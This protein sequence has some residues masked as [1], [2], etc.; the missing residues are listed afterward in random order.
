MQGR[1][2]SLRVIKG[3]AERKRLITDE[4]KR[5]RTE[6]AKPRPNWRKVAE[7]RQWLLV[8]KSIDGEYFA[9]ISRIANESFRRLQRLMLEGNPT[10]SAIRREIDQLIDTLTRGMTATL[11]KVSS[12]RHRASKQDLKRQLS[13]AQL[14]AQ[15]GLPVSLGR[16][17]PQ[18]G[19][20]GRIV[21][22]GMSLAEIMAWASPLLMI[23]GERIAEDQ[24][25]IEDEL[26]RVDPAEVVEREEKEVSRQYRKK[27]NGIVKNLNIANKISN[28]LKADGERAAIAEAKRLVLGND[29]KAG[30]LGQLR[31]E[32]KHEALRIAGEHAE[33]RRKQLDDDILVG[34]ILYSRFLASSAPDHTARDGWRF[35]RDNRRSDNL[36]KISKIRPWAQRRIP[37]YRKNCV[38]FTQ[39]IFEDA[40]GDEFYAEFSVANP[41]L[42]GARRIRQSDVGAQIFDIL[43]GR[44]R[45]VT[46]DDVGTVIAGRA[47]SGPAGWRHIEP[48]DVGSW[49]TW[50]NE[51]LPYVKRKI[52]GEKRY[53]AVTGRGVERPR[54]SHFIDIDQS[55][56]STKVLREQGRARFNL[57]TQSVD[58]QIKTLE[59]LYRRAWEEGGNKWQLR[60]NDEEK[61]LRRLQVVLNRVL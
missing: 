1:T 20:V 36:P 28:T 26:I 40:L 27:P 45:A 21:S 55:W 57:R 46:Q 50:F 32:V 43:D 11:N 33:E 10:P 25:P 23:R 14:T 44:L 35:Y 12:D 17:R 30:L 39:D 18:P 3:K 2:N 6:L 8:A 47:D 54:Y 53:D 58:S 60:Q 59:R 61:M 9:P 52:V 51:Q 15:T 38:C 49:S 31:N 56:L 48:R 37:P 19:Q 41:T 22:F 34:Y 5:L 42:S 24:A 4:L 16:V 29:S 7:L 13:D